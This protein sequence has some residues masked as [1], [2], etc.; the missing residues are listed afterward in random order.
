MKRDYPELEGKVVKY[1]YTDGTSV[2]ALVVGVNYDIGITL[3]GSPKNDIYHFCLT[4]PL[5]PLWKDTWGTES[6]RRELYDILFRN[7]VKMIKEKEVAQK[8]IDDICVGR[9]RGSGGRNPSASTCS[10]AA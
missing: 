6:V 3:T 1:K 8:T 9:F 2:D 10:F 4:G 7:I 5:S